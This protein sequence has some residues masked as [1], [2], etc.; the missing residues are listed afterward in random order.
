MLLNHF[1]GWMIDH[2]TSTFWISA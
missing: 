1:I 2:T